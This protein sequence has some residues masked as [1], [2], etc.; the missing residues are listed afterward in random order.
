VPSANK[1][2][3]GKKLGQLTWH[4]RGE[5]EYPVV[6]FILG[7]SPACKLFVPTFRK[8]VCFIFVGLPVYTTYE[9]GTECSEKSAHTIQMPG[10]HQTETVQQYMVNV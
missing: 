2:G 1:K 5:K 9:C 3:E 6:L 8:N 7:V 10:N 4:G